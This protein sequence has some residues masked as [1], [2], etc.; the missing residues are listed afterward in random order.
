[1]VR[2]DVIHDEFESI[3]AQ[4]SG[5]CKSE[6]VPSVEASIHAARSENATAQTVFGTDTESL[7]GA[8]NLGKGLDVELVD[9][10]E[11]ACSYDL[12]CS[13]NPAYLE[14]LERFRVFIHQA[15]LPADAHVLDLGAGTGNFFCFGL[16]DTTRR[17][18]LIHLD[19][20]SAMIERATRK[21]SARGLEVRTILADASTYDFPPSSLD[22]V[23]TVNAIYAMHEPAKVLVNVYRWLKP[24]G[25]LFFVNLGRIQNT[26]EWTA[27][28]L[29]RNLLALGLKRTLSILSSEGRAISNA[30][31]RITSAQRKRRYW[32]HSTE[33]IGDRLSSIGFATL[34]L[35]ACYRGY[36]DVAICRKPSLGPVSAKPALRSAKGGSSQAPLALHSL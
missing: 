31:R 17:S 8:E 18:T 3:E 19:A 11:Y 30:N 12:L 26:L 10:H 33:E 32:R 1:M 21:Y 27:Y 25:F 24:G 36:S 15:S 5:L 7:V 2:Y 23:V 35:G 28:L 29:S 22:C 9:W 13:L 4:R 14:L 34:T 16:A 6:P 20:N